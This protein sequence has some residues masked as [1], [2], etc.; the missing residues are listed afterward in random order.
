MPTVG[1]QVARY[2]RAPFARGFGFKGQL[3]PSEPR[4]SLVGARQRLDILRMEDDPA[5]PGRPSE[6]SPVAPLL[7]SFMRRMI[8]PVAE[9]AVAIDGNTYSVPWR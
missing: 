1:I 3:R 7:A 5:F 6:H 2:A 4:L 9:C 8:K